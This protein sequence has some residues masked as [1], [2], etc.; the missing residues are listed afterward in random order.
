MAKDALK[1]LIDGIEG[2][3]KR[4]AGVVKFSIRNSNS[5]RSAAKITNF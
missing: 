5:V 2:F 1:V 4:V 3:F